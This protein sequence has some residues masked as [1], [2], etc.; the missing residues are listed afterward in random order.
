MD[1]GIQDLLIVLGVIYSV[2]LLVFG[3]SLARSRRQRRIEEEM[4]E[5]RRI[6]DREEELAIE[7]VET[8]ENLH[9]DGRRFREPL[10]TGEWL[11]RPENNFKG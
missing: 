1:K 3:Y 4:A 5:R 7:E 11:N 6:E 8:N 9:V 10:S 2:A